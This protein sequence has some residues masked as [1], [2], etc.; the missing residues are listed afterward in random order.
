MATV[1]D[2]D[3][4]LIRLN[5]ILRD[6]G[7]PDDQGLLVDIGREVLRI[8]NECADYTRKTGSKCK[9]QVNVVI[10]FSA[11]KSERETEVDFHM[12]PIKTKGPPKTL[13]RKKRTFAGHDGEIS[14]VPV[15]EELPIMGIKGSVDGGKKQQVASISAQTV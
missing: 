10:D 3:N 5:V 4:A 1:N 9:G 15:Q 6:Q 12:Q 13:A 8:Y 2:P 7:N 11:F 14:T